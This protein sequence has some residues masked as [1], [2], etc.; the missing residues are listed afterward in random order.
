TRRNIFDI[1]KIED[2]WWAGKLDETEFLSRI[3][4]LES[5]PSTD[6]R[7]ENAIGDIW[8]HRINNY[9]WE[10]DW[11]FSDARF[12]LLNCDDVTLLN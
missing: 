12:N 2:I 3:Y 9:D 8:Q 1:L 10:D 6:S 7:Y 4:D 5:M 11:I